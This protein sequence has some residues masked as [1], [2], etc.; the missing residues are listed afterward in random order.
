MADSQARLIPWLE[1]DSEAILLSSRQASKMIRLVDKEMPLDLRW[2][3]R[4]NSVG[5]I[6]K[7]K[8]LPVFSPASSLT[9]R[10]RMQKRTIWM[11]RKRR[12]SLRYSKRMTKED[13]SS[14][15]SSSRKMKKNAKRSWKPKIGWT[16]GELT[17]RNKSRTSTQWIKKLRR[18][19]M[20]TSRCRGKETTHG[21]ESSTTVSFKERIPSMWEVQK[22]Q[23]W[24]K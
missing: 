24:G 4:I 22:C 9:F 18:L 5:K 7:Y 8:L 10:H 19:S 15:R 1:Q 17:G 14:S 21:R 16:S 6:R 2:H 13:N 11:R 23:G 3:L 12:E 20:R